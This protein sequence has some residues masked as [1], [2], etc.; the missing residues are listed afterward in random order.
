MTGKSAGNDWY[1]FSSGMEIYG[2]LMG[3]AG[4]GDGSTISLDSESSIANH[5]QITA[6]VD[7]RIKCKKFEN[8]GKIV[9]AKDKEIRIECERFANKA[10]IDPKP[11]I[12]KQGKQ[13]M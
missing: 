9:T 10:V 6:D 12:I 7:I 13:M 2:F 4:D 8:F 1:L 5:G 3:G 11:T